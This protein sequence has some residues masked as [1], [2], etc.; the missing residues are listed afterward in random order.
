MIANADYLRNY[1][2]FIGGFASGSF[3]MRYKKVKGWH[4]ESYWIIGVTPTIWSCYSSAFWASLKKWNI[5]TSLF[6]C[7]AFVVSFCRHRLQDPFSTVLIAGIPPIIFTFY[8]LLFISRNFHLLICNTGFE[9]KYLPGSN[10]KIIIKLYKR[11]FSKKNWDKSKPVLSPIPIFMQKTFLIGFLFFSLQSKSQTTISPVNPATLNMGGGSATIKPSF[12]LD[13]SIGESTIIETYYGENSYSNGSVGFKWN[14]TSGVLQPFDK[15]HIIFSP[16]T[17]YWTMEEIRLYPI[18]TPDVVFIDFRSTTT[19][20]ISIQLLS[21]DGKLLGLKEF[22][23]FNGY[24]TQSWDLTNRASGSYYFKILLSSDEGK[25][26]KQG[27]FK[28][29][30]IK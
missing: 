30:K 26:L 24:S 23:Q 28:I 22:Y 25:I 5:D 12:T 21:I 9:N 1:F 2:H 27:T 14:V 13:W 7:M 20:K 15:N 16:L 18:P 19:G 6:G 29:E 4:W 10:I 8:H 11:C 17:P 3:Y